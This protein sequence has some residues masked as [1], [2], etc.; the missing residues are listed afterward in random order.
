MQ[1]AHAGNH[2]SGH[3]T[4]IAKRAA[5]SAALKGSRR[6]RRWKK[7]GRGHASNSAAIFLSRSSSAPDFAGECF[8]IF[9]KGLLCIHKLFVYKDASLRKHLAG[10]ATVKES[11]SFHE[12]ICLCM[13]HLAAGRWRSESCR[14]N[15]DQIKIIKKKHFCGSSRSGTLIYPRVDAIVGRAVPLK[16]TS[17]SGVRYSAISSIPSQRLTSLLR[18]SRRLMMLAPHTRKGQKRASDGKENG[19]GRRMN[20]IRGE[21]VQGEGREDGGA[22]APWETLPMAAVLRADDLSLSLLESN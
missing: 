2:E 14:V 15:I 8:G 7:R 11:G 16:R 20:G 4:C 18:Y 5:P 13:F 21:K 19:E 17:P 22:F 9:A 1:A 10:T 12:Y 6:R 3:H